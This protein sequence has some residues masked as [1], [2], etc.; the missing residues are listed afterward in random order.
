MLNLV[1]NFSRLGPLVVKFTPASSVKLENCYVKV[2]II[3]WKLTVAS[4]YIIKI[5][6]VHKQPFF[7]PATE[8]QC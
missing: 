8:V 4:V 7:F 1:N 5:A 2:K 6:E 3:E